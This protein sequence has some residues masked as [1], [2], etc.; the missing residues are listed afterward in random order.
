MF[1]KTCLYFKMVFLILTSDYSEIEI[2]SVLVNHFW[3]WMSQSKVQK[4]SDQDIKNEKGLKQLSSQLATLQY[5]FYNCH[6]NFG[7]QPYNFQIQLK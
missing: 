2:F 6:Y 4:L 1:V 3:V 5:L 7:T